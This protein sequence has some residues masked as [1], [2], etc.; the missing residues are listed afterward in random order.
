MVRKVAKFFSRDGS[1]RVAAVVLRDPLR[2]MCETQELSPLATMAVSRASVAA[3][4]MASHMREDQSLG[5]YFHGDGILGGVYAEA[6]FTGEMRGYCGVPNAELP[7]VRG[8][9]DVASAIGKGHL[10][11]IRNIPFQK[12][13]TVGTVAIESGDIAKDLCAYMHQSL[14]TPSVIALSSILDENGKVLQSGGLLVELMPGASESTI[15]ALEKQ[16]PHAA[17]LSELMRE[18]A[19]PVDLIAEYVQTRLDP[20]DHDYEIRFVCK[21]SKNR[22]YRS[23]TLLGSETI[24]DMLAEKKKFE[25]KCE[26]CGKKY[27]LA[28][29]DLENI[30]MEMKRG[31]SPVIH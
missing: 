4:L 6:H 22:I 11:V 30:L 26:F 31:E 25:I 15:I 7:L 5:I 27:T 17:P 19:T 28:P 8:S 3:I 29:K 1:I 18:G 13:P 14:Q 2:Q 16:I 23:L 20:I 12:Q 24:S 10:T 9:F 21:C